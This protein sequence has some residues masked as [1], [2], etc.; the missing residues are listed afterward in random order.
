MNEII[1]QTIKE[2][3]I[4]AVINEATPDEYMELVKENIEAILEEERE[5]QKQSAKEFDPDPVV[6]SVFGVTLQELQQKQ[7]GKREICDA[8]HVSMYFM[9]IMTKKSLSEI[10]SKYGNR[11]HATVIHAEKKVKTLR[12]VDVDFRKKVDLVEGYLNPKKN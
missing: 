9:K 12:E 2:C 6:C 3:Y 8:R 5:K 11:D 7:K 4:D 10:G 1:Y